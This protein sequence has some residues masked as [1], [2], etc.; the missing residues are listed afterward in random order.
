MSLNLYIEPEDAAK[1][2]LKLENKNDAFF[3]M[4]I[5]GMKISDAVQQMIMDIDGSIYSSGSDIRTRYGRLVDIRKLSTSCKTAINVYCNPDKL[6]NC[7]E[8]GENVLRYILKFKHGNAFM[9]LLPSIIE[10]FEVDVL[11]HYRGKEKHCNHVMQIW[12]MWETFYK[13]QG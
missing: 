10:D 9:P 2:G 7:V 8:A 4:H 12:E 6:F 3:N 13:W 11:L 1:S 5:S